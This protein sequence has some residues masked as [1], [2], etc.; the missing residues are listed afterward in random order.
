MHTHFLQSSDW[1]AF[2]TAVGHRSIPLNSSMYGYH[3]QIGP[4]RYAYIPRAGE[5]TDA[6]LT[7][8]KKEYHWV[9][10]EGPL[11]TTCKT[12]PV[13]TR[14]PQTTLI[15]DLSE[16]E[17]EILSHMHSKTRYNIRLAIRK[18]VTVR[19]GADI[20]TFWQLHSETTDRD[21]FGGHTKEYYAKFLEMPMAEQFTAYI[22]DTPIAAIITVLHD[23]VMTYVH[24]ASANAHR[25]LMAPYLLQWEAMR[26]A[27]QR[28][29]AQYDFWG[30]SPI[31]PQGEAPTETCYNGYCWTAT[32]PWTGIT[33]F[34]VGFGG[35]VVTYRD[36]QDV[37]FSPLVYRL[38]QYIHRLRYGTR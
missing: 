13:K 33:R 9:R 35:T 8:L 11:N 34:K 20:D 6:M 12:H 3:M 38:Y 16:S 22:D 30:I 4:F 32:H 5:M 25:N 36:A 31:Y 24:G 15:L 10:V 7:A 19:S 28:G 29:A 27:K 1:A 18:G 26:Y 14:Q 23:G 2:Q 21:G 17:D 37:I